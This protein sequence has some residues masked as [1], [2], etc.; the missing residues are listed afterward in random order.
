MEEV[1]SL[2]GS[3]EILSSKVSAAINEAY[4]GLRSM[5]EDEIRQDRK[6]NDAYQ[7]LKTTAECASLL[8]TKVDYLIKIGR[9]KERV[10][11][12]RNGLV[13]T[14]HDERYWRLLKELV[15][16]LKRAITRIEQAYSE[17]KK[18]I[19]AAIKSTNNA[20]KA[21]RLQG[22]KARLEAQKT[23]LKGGIGTS[24]AA[25]SIIFFSVWMDEQLGLLAG[26][27]GAT[28]ASVAG[29]AITKKIV[30]EFESQEIVLKKQYA[31]LKSWASCADQLRE[32]VVSVHHTVGTLEAAV[33]DLQHC[34]QNR[35]SVETL[36]SDLDLLKESFTE[37]STA[38]KRCRPTIQNSKKR[39]A[40]GLAEMT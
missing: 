36:C 24:V 39:M 22:Q 33:D 27:A 17:F 12:V 30:G 38:S 19:D 9:K 10:S 26:V 21:C 4:A 31:T 15:D 5:S 25:G 35:E 23:K 7:D 2:F 20:A 1:S 37:V 11:V 34:Q 14:T 13:E 8:V 32:S 18:S 16:Q 3:M 29:F 6:V 28:V 40:S